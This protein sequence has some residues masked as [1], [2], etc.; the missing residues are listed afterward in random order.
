MTDQSRERFEEKVAKPKQMD[1][2]RFS[3]TYES[4]VTHI[5][6]LGWLAAEQDMLKRVRAA[7]QGLIVEEPE[8][9]ELSRI[10]KEAFESVLA[11]LDRVFGKG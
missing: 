3:D 11:E 2:K 1:L 9:V 4:P 7:V 6:W 5:A 8:E 10:H